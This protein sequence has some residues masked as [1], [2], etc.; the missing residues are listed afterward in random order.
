M[1]TMLTRPSRPVRFIKKLEDTSVIVGQPLK[2]VCTYTGS[3]RVHVTWKKDDKLIWASY[4]YN[5]LTTD[6]TCSLEVLYSD[7]PA[8][9]G[10]YSCEIS[11]EAG[12]DVCHA[13][14]TLGKGTSNN[15]LT[16]F[17][18]SAHLPDN[19]LNFLRWCMI[20]LISLLT[21]NNS[22]SLFNTGN[23]KQSLLQT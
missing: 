20:T 23:M 13:H 19:Y 1:T 8:A 21:E 5:V 6:S 2:L 14:V 22:N 17:H 12:R 9:A 3:Q 18:S 10:K 7:R 4:Q 15:L 11:N 16:A